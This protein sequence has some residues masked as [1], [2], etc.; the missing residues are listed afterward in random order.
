MTDYSNT[1]RAEL[2]GQVERIVYSDAASGFTIAKLQ[3]QD[4][5][6]P[7]TI[8]GNLMAPSPGLTIALK[9]QWVQHPK[10]GR[11]FR[12]QQFESREPTTEKGIVAYLGSGQIKGIGRQMAGRIVSQFG[13][14]TLDII[15]H[16]P[17]QLM[18]VP[19]IG[20][21]R[22]NQIRKAWD[23]QR[24]I[25]NVMLFLQSHGVSAAYALKIFNRYGQASITVVQQNPYRLADD[26]VGIG[27]RIADKIAANLG[28]KIDSPQ[29]LQAGIIYVLSRLADEGH[30]FYPSQ[31]LI[32]KAHDM[33]ESNRES[34]ASAIWEL[35]IQQKVIVENLK[36]DG[37]V[38]SPNQ[39]AVYLSKLHRCEVYVSQYLTRLL[40]APGYS[41]PVD[42]HQGVEWIQNRFKAVLGQDQRRAIEA[43]LHQKVLI[44]TGGPGTG[45]TTIIQAIL[46]L[47][48][49]IR[50]KV[51]LTAP[52]G[53]AAKRLAET[54][55]RPAKTIHR[56]LAYNPRQEG[57][58]KNERNPLNADLLVVDETSMIDIVLMYALLK[59]IRPNTCLIM[60][61]DVNQLPSVGPG[62]VLKD[63]LTSKV[64]P[65]VTL[66]R[67]FRQARHSRIILNAHRINAGKM[68]ILDPAGQEG[69]S[70][71]YFIEQQESD[72]ILETI[73]TLVSRRIPNRFNLD[74]V[75]D[76]QVLTPMNRGKLGSES[77]NRSLQQI[78]NP[79]DGH[80]TRGDVRFGLHDKVM[81]TR[82][83]YE[84]EVYNGDLGR[85]TD[86]DPQAQK[87]LIQFDTRS[88][89]YDFNEMDEL[90]LA[91]AVSVHKSQGSEYP[92]VV[93]PVT[94][95]HYLLLQRNLI[96][97]ALTR[98]KKL[99]VMVG[100]KRAL[101]M[102]VKNAKP[103]QRLT[104]L[105]QRL[106]NIANGRA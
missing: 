65:Q 51:L 6:E 37:Q 79:Q 5:T 58:G 53:R 95:A 24:H 18:K 45:K 93:I 98:A 69:L 75:N 67:I 31:S 30:L 66:R 13:N 22:I 20:P 38:Q 96:Y 50:A 86:I 80:V 33:L 71:F 7:V 70:D 17:E 26:I 3:V 2:S 19:G 43:A 16:Q 27:F 60:V 39:K 48:E 100:T 88:V 9:G 62:Q 92:A 21:K 81:Q 44:I 35:A 68:P 91:Y 32:D 54:T 10:F 97:T 47:Y 90:A 56:L 40:K 77:L 87:V 42:A 4:E 61:G 12:V 106:Y 74:P 78:L 72:K 55:G 83:N 36:T 49:H 102:A 84:K 82:N 14:R 64:V 99:A 59:A 34:I 76:I 15:E 101:A 28:L 89:D 11:Q 1:N 57:F 73:I 105:A 63:I 94:T 104:L 103:Q 23:D 46:S 85:I 41:K 8:V 52:T 25:R 29:R